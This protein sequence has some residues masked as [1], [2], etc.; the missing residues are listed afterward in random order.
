[1]CDLDTNGRSEKEFKRGTFE[2]GRWNWEEV[3]SSATLFM[4]V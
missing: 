3:K 4:I 1:M 2:K